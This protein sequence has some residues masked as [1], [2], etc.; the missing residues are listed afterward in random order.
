MKNNI[1]LFLCVIIFSL[2]SFAQTN[3]NQ[4]FP[5]GT[6]IP[7]WFRDY[8]KIEL[9]DLGK[10]YT[11]T[12]FGVVN[13]STIIQTQKIQNVINKAAE[14]GGGVIIIPKGTY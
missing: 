14:N 9:K 10:K 3:N 5:D 7:A 4:V 11:I 13:D 1:K 12:D 2:A 8:H 6:P